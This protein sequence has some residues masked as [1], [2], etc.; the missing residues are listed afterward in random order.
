MLTLGVGL[1]SQTLRH[2]LSKLVPYL[3]HVVGAP[4]T[5]FLS[6]GMERRIVCS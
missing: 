3:G 5:W 1:D 4:G 2:G 6:V